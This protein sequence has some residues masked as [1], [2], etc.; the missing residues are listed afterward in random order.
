MVAVAVE[1]RDRRSLVGGDDAAR[2][3]DGNVHE[4]AAVRVGAELE[5]A[6]NRVEVDEAWRVAADKVQ[7][8]VS[9]GRVTEPDE[10]LQHGCFGGGADVP[11]VEQL[12]QE[13]D[14]LDDVELGQGVEQRVQQLGRP[15]CTGEREQP[16]AVRRRP[17]AAERP[18]CEQ[19]DHRVGVV[20]VLTQHRA[21]VLVPQD[22]QRSVRA[23]ALLDADPLHPG[24]NGPG[25]GTGVPRAHVGRRIRVTHA[26]SQAGPP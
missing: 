3:V 19:G 26:M 4:L 20:D 14:D 2:S 7:Q 22:V 18:D 25:I 1:P 13:G 9:H 15:R 5:D 21:G 23:T 12:V 6:R 8:P 10:P 11:A 24:A 16:W 17:T